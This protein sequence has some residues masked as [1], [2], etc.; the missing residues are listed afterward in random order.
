MTLMEIAFN[1]N[2]PSPWAIRRY[3]YCRKVQ[4]SV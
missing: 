2:C 4:V 1:T 3:K